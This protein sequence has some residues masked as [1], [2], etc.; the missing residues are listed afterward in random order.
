MFNVIRTYPAPTSL[1]NKKS[2]R[3]EDTIKMLDAIFFGKCYLCECKANKKFMEVDHFI[4][5]KNNPEKIYE[6][7]NL[8]YICR[9]CNSKKSSSFDNILDCSDVNINVLRLIRLSLT[10]IANKIITIEGIYAKDNSTLNEKIK[11]TCELL[12]NIYNL[13][14][15]A[16]WDFRDDIEKILAKLEFYKYMYINE[17]KVKALEYL[18]FILKKEHQYSAF[19]RWAVL[20]DKYLKPILEQYID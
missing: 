3:K 12:N 5:K 16:Y 14:K 11:H 6:W 8:F 4:S 2:Y 20:E 1:A 9:R 17:N 15:L 19:I 18:K 7:D 10:N 13:D